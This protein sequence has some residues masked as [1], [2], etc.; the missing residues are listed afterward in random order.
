MN[1]KLISIIL[2]IYNEEKHIEKTY[3]EIIKICQKL[4]HYKYE[5]LL[6]DDGSIDNSWH[7]IRQI[8]KK[9]FQI[10]AFR[11]SKNFG[12]QAALTAGYK[13]CK[14]DNAIT[15]DADLQHPPML[16]E[17]LIQKWENGAKIVY[18]RR[19]KRNDNK[20]KKITAYYYQSILNSIADITIPENITDFRLLD[21]Q[22]INE[23]NRYPERS[24]YLRG[25]IAWTGFSPEYVDFMQPA[26]EL[27]STKYKWHQ[28]FKIA[29][30]GI[31]GFSMLPLRISAFIGSFVIFSGIAML[32]IITID[33]LFFHGY[34][35]LF[36]WLVT[37]IYIFI[38]LL[39]ILV[40]I[41]GEYIGR[42]YEELKGRP[43]F[44]IKESINSSLLL[45]EK[46]D[47]YESDAHTIHSLKTSSSR[48]SKNR[49]S[50][51]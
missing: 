50:T 44:I 42:I 29:F 28:L 39:F 19:I 31:I 3:N 37:I 45:K 33:A 22:V 21:R 20:L 43:L 18:A 36:K 7:I 25:M 34:Y 26:R 41:L 51:R 8:Q 23:I 14:G 5:L 17:E 16:I 15:M 24:R 11:F 46:K 13:Y 27:D 47:C 4:N 10:K 9:D 2:P 40:W 49:N 30:D 12:Y 38:G 48:L 1:K 6:I 35:P 32:T